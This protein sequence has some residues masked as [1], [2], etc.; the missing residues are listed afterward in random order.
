MTIDRRSFVSTAS[1][2][3]MLAMLQSLDPVAISTAV[4]ATPFPPLPEGNLGNGHRVVIIG[5]GIAGL[6]AAYE[7]KKRGFHCTILEGD[8]RSGGRNFTIRR[9]TIVSETG[10]LDQLCNFDE[11]LYMNA[12]PA[13]LASSHH[14]MLD[15]CRQFNIELEAFINFNAN[16]LYVSPHHFEG[17]PVRLRQLDL[18]LM[19][20]LQTVVREAVESGKPGNLLSEKDIS[21]LM[22][23]FQ[24][25]T[26]AQSGRAMGTPG[27]QGDPGHI[28]TIAL[29][30]LL[31]SQYWKATAYQQLDQFQ[32]PTLLQPVGGM[33]RIVAGFETALAGII[34]TQCTVRQIENRKNGVVVSWWD[35]GT[36]QQGSLTADYCIASIPAPLFAGIET[37]FS[38]PYREALRAVRFSRGAKLGWQ[39]K[40]R[41]WEEQQSIYG[42]ISFVDH[43]IRQFWYPSNGYQKTSA[44]V[45]GAYPLNRDADRFANR[46]FSARAQ[47]SLKGAELLHPGIGKVLQHPISI[48]WHRQ[49]LAAGVWPKWKHGFADPAFKSLLKAEGRTFLAGD[50]ISE[51]PG[52][53]EGAAMSAQRVVG[54]IIQA[55]VTK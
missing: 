1:T 44:I 12:G 43:P 9:G 8:N 35:A 10:N 17:K 46:P 29:Q 31:R 14:L 33:D 5:A 19:Q 22:Q 48:V 55:S 38:A 2:S 23:Q 25:Y 45:V 54:K 37:N 18:D 3:A 30:Q 7:L 27:S 41:S 15:Y 39:A 36:K 6:V 24:R 51:L 49:R 16:A 42:G 40:S 26:I 28:A 11:G 52:W 20:H 13:R 50:Q 4:G 47:L 53:Q 34:K 32:Q 21:L